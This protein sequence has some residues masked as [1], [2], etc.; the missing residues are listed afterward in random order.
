MDKRNSSAAGGICP[1]QLV[2]RRWGLSCPWTTLF[3]EEEKW[4]LGRD[5][6][7]GASGIRVNSVGD[8]HVSLTAQ[9]NALAREMQ[10][11]VTPSVRHYSLE[12]LVTGPSGDPAAD[13]MARA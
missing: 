3:T 5:G 9:G 10:L 11:R 13:L 4:V 7:W 6:Q 12:L 2:V 1:K 8:W